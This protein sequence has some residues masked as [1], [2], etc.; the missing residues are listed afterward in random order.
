MTPDEILAALGPTELSA[1]DGDL[2]ARCCDCGGL[3]LPYADGRE[4]LCRRC[5]YHELGVSE[6]ELSLRV[7]FALTRN[8]F[9]A[10]LE[11]HGW[12]WQNLK[13]WITPKN[14]LRR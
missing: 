5:T 9:D 3:R 11:K 1:V 13:A 8:T 12:P 7:E 6:M 2:Y 4:A 14:R 10:R